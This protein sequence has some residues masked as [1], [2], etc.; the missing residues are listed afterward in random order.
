MT[1]K[2]YDASIT[3]TSDP[4]KQGLLQWELPL[5]PC[6]AL[7]FALVKSRGVMIP[8]DGYDEFVEKYGILIEIF[9]DWLHYFILNI[10]PDTKDKIHSDSPECDN[11]I[12][13]NCSDKLYYTFKDIFE[14]VIRT[15]KLDLSFERFPLAPIVEQEITISDVSVFFRGYD[16][17]I[18]PI[19]SSDFIEPNWSI[20]KEASF[21]IGQLFSGKFDVDLTKNFNRLDHLSSTIWIFNMGKKWLVSSGSLFP[22]EIQ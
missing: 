12:D 6:D 4:S 18:I 11:I 13:P 3:G 14:G 9:S 7:A 20:P 2:L 10:H 17:D 15:I 21:V 1:S 8:Y 22:I 16:V 5:E 19:I